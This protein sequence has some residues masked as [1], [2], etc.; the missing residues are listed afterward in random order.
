MDE[1]RVCRPL[2]EPVLPELPFFMFSKRRVDALPVQIEAT[3]IPSTYWR[4]VADP[5]AGFP[6]E[7]AFRIHT[8]VV[9]PRIYD[10][11]PSVPES[12]SLGRTARLCS[13]L[14]ISDSGHNLNCVTR[15]LCQLSNA[16][17]TARLDYRGADGLTY[18]LDA[19]FPRYTAHPERDGIQVRLS[20]P[21]RQLLCRA[22]PSF[23]DLPYLLPLPPG[24]Q[25]FYQLV[26]A[27]LH[28][29]I[30]HGRPIVMTYSEYCMRTSQARY[31]DREAVQKQMYKLHAPHIRSGYLDKTIHYHPF[32]HS[33]GVR[34]W[35]IE[36]AAGYR[37]RSEYDR[38]LKWRAAASWGEVRA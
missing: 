35:L 27:K 23:V 17:I 33:T 14:G 1:E 21:Y 37:A 15:A 8:F 4:V 19:E 38:A 20:A 25:R 16:Q 12:I 31:F 3:G 26:N 34:D 10:E 22:A 7:V 29:T 5:L 6:G 18:R 24:A 11:Y 32:T 36:Y 9:V 30:K 2:S 28:D 13:E